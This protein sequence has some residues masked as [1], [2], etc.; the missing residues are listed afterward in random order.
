MT[1]R[2]S[3]ILVVGAAHSILTFWFLVIRALIKYIWGE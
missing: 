2:Q 1:D 3:L